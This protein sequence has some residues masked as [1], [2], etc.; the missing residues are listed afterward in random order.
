ML[1][2]VRVLD[3]TRLLPGPYATLLLADLGAEVIK[4]EPPGSGDY[5]RHFQPRVD[6]T[7]VFF[8]AVNRNK[9]SITLN[10]KEERGREIFLQLVREVDVVFEGFRPGVMDNLGL[11]YEVL[12]QV[13]PGLVY[14]S[15]S[16]Y[17]QNGPYRDRAGHDI[18]YLSVSGVLGITGTRDG[19]PVVP[20]IQVADLTGGMFAV[21]GILAALWQK[22]R[23]GRGACIDMS[24]T[25]GLFS[26][27][28]IHLLNFMAAGAP[29]S[30]GQMML[31]GAL[32]C[33]NI[34]RTRDNGYVALGALEAKFWENFCRGVGRE[35]LVAG[36]MAP[37]LAENPVYKQVQDI[38]LSQPVQYWREFASRVDCCLTPVEDARQ[39][40]HGAYARERELFME[41]PLAGGGTTRQVRS[42]MVFAGQ[43]G[44]Q[45]T[46]PPVIGQHNDEIYGRLGLGAE[47]LARLQQAGII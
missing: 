24:M 29:A 10:L 39:V 21:V 18:N 30:P 44:A 7:S 19:Q 3:L 8:L 46:P 32:T 43:G 40:V 35:D 41:V 23:D 9:K 31:S 14:C 25:D 26:L 27:M 20:G 2:G 45:P 47:D 11:G 38:F 6:D 1:S 5:M 13:H 28:S 33:Y 4:L 16:G 17:G 34:Y 36:H 42:P 15:L 12:Q 22:K 37:A